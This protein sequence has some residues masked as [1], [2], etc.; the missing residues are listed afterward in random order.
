MSSQGGLWGSYS[1]AVTGGGGRGKGEICSQ[2][3]R[4]KQSWQYLGIHPP[5]LCGRP[6]INYLQFLT[7]K[8]CQSLAFTKWI[9][10][11]LSWCQNNILLEMTACWEEWKNSMIQRSSTLTIINCF[12]MFRWNWTHHFFFSYWTQQ[13]VVFVHIY[14]QPQWEVHW[15]VIENYFLLV[16]QSHLR[17]SIFSV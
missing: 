15:C 9:H 12:F 14:I 7:A 10:G 1:N 3:S 2:K 5:V 11:L 8:V 13:R 6:V 4:E 16:K 17:N